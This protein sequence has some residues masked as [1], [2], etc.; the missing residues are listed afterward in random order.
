LLAEYADEARAYQVG[1]RALAAGRRRRAA[2]RTAPIAVLLA[3][4][5]VGLITVRPALIRSDAVGTPPLPSPTNLTGFPAA[6][7]P[8]PDAPVLPTNRAVGPG[9]HVYSTYDAALGRSVGF[10]VVADGEHYRLDDEALSSPGSSF[11]L[12]R[13]GRWLMAVAPDRQ[14]VTATLWD[15][16][17][18]KPAAHRLTGE[19]GITPDGRW[20]I[21]GRLDPDDPGEIQLVDLRRGI[22]S[23][24][25]TIDLSGYPGR[26]VASVLPNGDLVLASIAPSTTMD[27]SIVDHRTVTETRRI[28]V[29]L[30]PHLTPAEVRG[31]AEVD[32][33]NALAGSQGNLLFTEDGLLYYQTTVEYV[34]ADGG[35][36]R[37]FTKDVLV[38]DLATQRV[39]ERLVLPAPR[40][41]SGEPDVSETWRLMDV[42]PEGLLLE[43]S[44]TQRT[45]SWELF[46]PET[47]E[48][49]LVTDLTALPGK[50]PSS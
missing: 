6:I 5:V 13:D 16:T 7:V 22:D 47:R 24:P 38:I 11:V 36:P 15:L 12:S 10:L 14:P 46:K 17:A 8:R 48:L 27:L 26:Q 39:R 33:H 34:A 42:R 44:T 18:A 30:A 9:V 35:N 29:D 40:P 31:E 1:A 43:H 25:T 20:L 37:Y 45:L 19:P 4:A 50:L 49:F 32:V 41:S 3:V 2:R 28:R 21:L 23:R